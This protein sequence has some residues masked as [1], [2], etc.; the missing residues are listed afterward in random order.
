MLLIRRRGHLLWIFA[1]LLVVW[2]AG[3][4]TLPDA[5]TPD[6]TQ[7]VTALVNP[8]ATPATET[9]APTATETSTATATLTPTATT[10]SI[11]PTTSM[12][13]DTAEPDATAITPI[14]TA[15]ISPTPPPTPDLTLTYTPGLLI[16]SFSA[17]PA[18]IDPG[19]TITLSWSAQGDTATIYTLTQGGV[20]GQWWEVPLV[21][22]LEVETSASVRNSASYI[23]YVG[24]GELL[25]SATASVTV[26]CVAEWFF[27][28]EPEICPLDEVLQSAAAI[29]RFEEGL[30]IW[31]GEMDRILVLY[32][33]G[34]S[35]AYELLLDEWDSSLPESDPTI[36]PPEGF[37]QPVRGFGLLWRG[38]SSG[39]SIRE[40]LGWA[41]A[42]EQAYDALWQ[43]NSPSKYVTCY[44]SGPGGE[45][46]TL[47]PER[48]GWGLTNAILR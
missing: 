24:Q 18:E 15:S 10:D 16:D 29:Q 47:E 23:L 46:Y 21:G 22:S 48:S 42:P 19:D 9:S 27:S 1:L 6:V 25:D 13:T 30:M 40:R 35:P 11:T 45:V 3:C 8:T 5:V 12:G 17:E 43:C 4:G 32:G 38:E 20:L 7:T 39:Y 28:P 33:D 34:A 26:R 37:Y 31:I 41:L 44:V 36:E 2:L 14:V